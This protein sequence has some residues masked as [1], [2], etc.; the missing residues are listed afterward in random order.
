MVIILRIKQV[1]VTFLNSK[2]I[3]LAL[4]LRGTGSSKGEL[5]K[6]NPGTIRKTL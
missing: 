1:M 2:N 4:P 3:P 5:K 6:Q